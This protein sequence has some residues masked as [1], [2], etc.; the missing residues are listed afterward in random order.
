HHTSLKVYATNNA[1]VVNAAVGF[2]E[3]TLQPTYELR[4]GV[5]G[6][7]AGINI[8]SRLGLNPQIISSARQR[9]GTQTKDISQFLD[10]LHSELRELGNERVHIHKR[11][12][13]LAREKE[14]LEREGQREQRAKVQ[15]MERKLEAVLRDFEYRA[16]E[17]VTAVQERAA[18]LKLGKEADRRIAKLRREFKEQFD[19]TLVA[20]H[21][22]ADSGD[23]NARPGMVQ[24]AAEGDTIKIKS[25][26]RPGVI[27]RRLDENTFEV[28]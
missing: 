20:H 5:P 3:K 15:E 10:K 13:E 19:S 18:A 16:R 8:A 14:R 4:V 27:K 23:P 9:L 26:G 12:Q 21:T 7:S 17:T 6:A 24:N 22:G 1:G 28:E 25:L 2:D 11:E